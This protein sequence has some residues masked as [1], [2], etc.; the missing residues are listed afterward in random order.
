MTSLFEPRQMPP[1]QTDDRPCVWV[2]DAGVWYDAVLWGWTW[3]PL[4]RAFYG[5]A[6]FYAHNRHR[7]ELVHQSRIRRHQDGPGD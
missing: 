3:Q 2:E 4:A 6:D 1:F 5:Y 7:L